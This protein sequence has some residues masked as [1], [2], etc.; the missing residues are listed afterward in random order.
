MRHQWA[1]LQ[2]RSMSVKAEG[3]AKV[4]LMTEVT[5]ALHLRLCRE[6]C[7]CPVYKGSDSFVSCQTEMLGQRSRAALRG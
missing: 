3:P 1:E 7:V 6:S 5:T 2:D 4:R